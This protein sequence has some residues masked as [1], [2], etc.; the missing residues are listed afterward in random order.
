MIATRQTPKRRVWVGV[1]SKGAL[2]IGVVTSVATT[3]A[4]Q[5]WAG[6]TGNIFVQNSSDEP[7]VV[8]IRGLNEAVM[9][10]CGVIAEDPGGLLSDD[11]FGWSSSFNLEPGEGI[12]ISVWTDCGAALVETDAWVGGPRLAF[13]DPVELPVE[14]QEWGSEDPE[15]TLFLTNRGLRDDGGLVVARDLVPDEVDPSCDPGDDGERLYWSEVPFNTTAVIEGLD[16]APDGC[17]ELDFDLYNDTFY[18]CMPPELF[19]WE[20]GDSVAIDGAELA[21][22]LHSPE[23]RLQL[24]RT[25]HLPSSVS[26]EGDVLADCPYT[27][28]GCGNVSAAMT[29]DTPSEGITDAGDNYLLAVVHYENRALVVPE[30]GSSSSLGT[31]LEWAMLTWSAE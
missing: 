21:L 15:R 5:P 6:S 12:G 13:F 4:R 9:M 24:S 8:T 11:A 29:L 10:D 16:L 2:L 30:C 28:D 3:Q 26:D 7:H 19:F 17:F 14:Q 1:A 27:L 31:D 22:T 23:A 18:L 25:G 20:E